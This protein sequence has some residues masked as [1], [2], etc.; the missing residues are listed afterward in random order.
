MDVTQPR[1][2]MVFCLGGLCYSEQHDLF[3]LAGFDSYEDID[4]A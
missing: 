4:V 1:T 2:G 3:I